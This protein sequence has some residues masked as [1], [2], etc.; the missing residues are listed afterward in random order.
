MQPRVSPHAFAG[1][2]D[3][4]EKNGVS[5][6]S[7]SIVSIEMSEAMDVPNREAIHSTVVVPL[8]R[9]TV[10]SVHGVSLEE[11]CSPMAVNCA[12]QFSSTHEFTVKFPV[13]T[14]CM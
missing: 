5:V 12:V 2:A 1:L 10:T 3:V 9:A 11:C 7:I 4:T 6:S 14:P 13:S 8:G